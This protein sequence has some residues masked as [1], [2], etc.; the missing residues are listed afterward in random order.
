ML[1]SYGHFRGLVTLGHYDRRGRI[2]GAPTV[3]K[4]NLV[5]LGGCEVLA[6][7]LT[8]D[9]AY[10][11]NGV[12]FEFENT[13]GTPAAVSYT[14]STTAADMRGLAGSLTKGV[15]RSFL[16]SG[17]IIETGDSSASGLPYANNRATFFAL[18]TAANDLAGNTVFGSAVNSKIV[19]IG[20]LAL[21]VAADATK[22][23]LFARFTPATP[24]AVQAGRSPGV[25]WTVELL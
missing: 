20:L 13:A 16:A 4:P 5:T 15:V 10:K 7:A 3:L 14:R 18:A 17:G 23:V 21:P 24:F 9:V 11:I 1:D 19:S 2:V 12:Y 6:R 25:T 8:G 22:D